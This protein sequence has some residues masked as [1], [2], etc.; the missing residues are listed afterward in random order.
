MAL[1]LDWPTPASTSSGCLPRGGSARRRA[2][3]GGMPLVN[4]LLIAFPLGL[5]ALGALLPG[6]GQPA[7]GRGI[8]GPSTATCCDVLGSVLRRSAVALAF[9]LTVPRL[10][11]S[12]LREGVVYR[13]YGWRY[14]LERLVTTLTNVGLFLN[15]FGDSSLIVHYLRVLGYDVSRPIEQTGSNSVRRS[16][17]LAVPVHH[18]RGTMVSDGLSMLNSQYSDSSFRLPHQ[19]RGAQLLRQRGRLPTERQGRRRLPVRNQDHGADRRGDARRRGASAPLRS[20]FP[21]P[22]AGTPR[23]TT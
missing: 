23:S 2:V 7:P 12:G 1:P 17:R 9:I 4:R 3:F 10:L 18:G 21:E 13:L 8:P 14:F 6:P 11:A 16:S 5:A 15:L 19:H 20:R 22:C